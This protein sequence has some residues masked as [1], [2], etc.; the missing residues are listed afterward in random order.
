MTFHHE[1]HRSFCIRVAG[2]L[3]PQR[4]KSVLR[5]RGISRFRRCRRFSGGIGFS[6]RFGRFHRIIRLAR[7]FE[8]SPVN[9]N[10]PRMPSPSASTFTRWPS[11][12]SP[13]RIFSEMASSMS[14]W[15]TRRSGRA[16]AA[17]PK[18]F[19]AEQILGRVGQFER[20][21]TVEQ[22]VVELLDIQVDDLAHLRSVSCL[23]T[24]MSS[25][26]FRN[27]GRNCCLSSAETC[28]FMRW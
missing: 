11:S 14:R 28:S 24:M 26:R 3:T 12:R 15:I 7:L 18:P 4:W 19:C 13:I 2:V 8:A 22:T 9:V 6:G 5:L 25:R 16:P 1:T 27:S 23:N 10:S 20:H 17:G 21:V